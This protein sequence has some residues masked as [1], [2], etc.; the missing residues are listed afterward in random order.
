MRIFFLIAT[1]PGLAGCAGVSI[2]V[3]IGGVS[4]GTTVMANGGVAVGAS[5]RG[6]SIGMS[7]RARSN[8][9]FEDVPEGAS[10]DD[11]AEDRVDDDPVAS[12]GS[13]TLSRNESD[14]PD[15]VE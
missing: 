3:P 10:S 11:D 13:A 5:T 8:P 14:N 1:M 7:G 4:I 15:E 6:G 12:E 2:G 9:A